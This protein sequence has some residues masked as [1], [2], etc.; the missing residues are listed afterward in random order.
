MNVEARGEGTGGRQGGGEMGRQAQGGA[1]RHHPPPF[2]LQ[3]LTRILSTCLHNIHHICQRCSGGGLGVA[4]AQ[5]QRR[6]V[7]GQ[8]AQQRVLRDWGGSD[9]GTSSQRSVQ[10]CCQQGMLAVDPLIQQ[11]ERQERAEGC[12]ACRKA[13]AAIGCVGGRRQQARHAPHQWLRGAGN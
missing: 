12:K 8:Q 3:R 7:L 13:C 2:T 11:Q 6:Q 9:G 10:L 1:L 4:A 5:A